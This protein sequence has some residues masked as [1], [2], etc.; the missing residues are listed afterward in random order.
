MKWNPKF[1]AIMAIAAISAMTI[2]AKMQK[3]TNTGVTIGKE[4]DVTYSLV[5]TDASVAEAGQ[6]GQLDVALLAIKEDPALVDTERV[7]ANTFAA[8]QIQKNAAFAPTTANLSSAEPGV[9]TD[10]LA[11][12]IAVAADEVAFTTTGAAQLGSS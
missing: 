11:Y 1:L 6:I 7:A 4:A 2:S 9:I 10:Q 3:A 8:V 5:V 12:K